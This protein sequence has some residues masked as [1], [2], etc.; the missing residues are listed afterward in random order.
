MACIPLE[1]HLANFAEFYA[2]YPRFLIAFR[3]RLP[4][5]SLGELLW[6]KSNFF[7]ILKEGSWGLQTIPP[8]LQK[9]LDALDALDRRDDAAINALFEENR[10]MFQEVVAAN[11]PASLVLKDCYR[12]GDSICFDRNS[13][14]LD[15]PDWC[16]LH[17]ENGR[18]PESF[19]HD[20]FYFAANLL[21]VI[22]EATAFAPFRE[23]AVFSWL[24]SYEGFLQF[25]PDEWRRN[26]A[27]IAD[28]RD[29]HRDGGFLGQ[30]VNREGGLNRANAE[31][32]LQNGRLKFATKC[33]HAP[34]EAVRD[35]ARKF[36]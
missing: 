22:D 2:F 29:F 25:F 35:H 27:E 15:H 13:V 14:N 30:L 7:V 6:Q 19:L 3:D 16:R 31:F 10:Q 18:Q 32:L 12:R 4:Q 8:Y 33:C 21:R 26:V 36:L 5:L 34:I 23:I 28:E 24:N 11:Y 17:L 9:F 20:K 1:K